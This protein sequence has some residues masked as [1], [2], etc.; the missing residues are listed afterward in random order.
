MLAWCASLLG[1]LR[2]DSRMLLGE[3][4]RLLLAERVLDDARSQRGI[5]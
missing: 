4:L 1:G 5:W 3:F 2:L